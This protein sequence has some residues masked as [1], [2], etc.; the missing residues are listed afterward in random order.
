MSCL[1]VGGTNSMLQLCLSLSFPSSF[2]ISSIVKS[3]NELLLNNSVL[4]LLWEKCIDE[5][6]LGSNAAGVAKS[7]L[8][9]GM[10][11]LFLFDKL[12]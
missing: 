2:N 5:F 7:L 4:L 3:T 9:C 8:I 11:E 12:V 10:T 6:M 1:S